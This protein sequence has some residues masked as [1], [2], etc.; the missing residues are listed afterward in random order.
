MLHSM[1]GATDPRTWGTY[2]SDLSL[3]NRGPSEKLFIAP[4]DSGYFSTKNI[5]A[6]PE[7]ESII[8]TAIEQSQISPT[9]SLNSVGS[10]ENSNGESLDDISTYPSR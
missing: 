6:R 3:Q 1:H 4:N 7:K 8:R 2:P 9:G 10:V 5:E